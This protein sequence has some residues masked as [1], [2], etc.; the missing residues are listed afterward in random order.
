VREGEAC[1][2]AHMRRV[3]DLEEHMTV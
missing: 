3:R 1:G 2:K